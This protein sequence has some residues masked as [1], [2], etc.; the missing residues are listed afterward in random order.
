MG[1]FVVREE[2]S[3][4]HVGLF[5][6]VRVDGRTEVIDRIVSIEH[7]VSIVEGETVTGIRFRDIQS[8][9]NFWVEG[10]TVELL[11]PIPGEPT[12]AEVSISEL[13]EERDRLLAELLEERTRNHHQR[14]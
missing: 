8:T 1:M 12:W 4:R 6:R 2:L 13:I 7:Q 10:D 14:R 9:R 3:A 11:D 5:A